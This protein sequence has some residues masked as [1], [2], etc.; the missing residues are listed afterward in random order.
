MVS[1]VA[2]IAL[3]AIVACPI[4]LGY[5]MNLSEITES[6]YTPNDDNLDV[7]NL[8]RDGTDYSYAVANTVDLNS[9]FSEGGIDSY[10]DF[11]VT[12]MRS[13]LPMSKAVYTN[14]VTAAT[15][16]MNDL[17]FHYMVADYVP[18]YSNYLQVAA[19]MNDNSISNIT[20]IHG[21]RFDDTNPGVILVSKF[22]YSNG[23]WIPSPLMSVSNVKALVYTVS[24]GFTGTCETY[25]YNKT[26]PPTT[27]ADL[28]F[29]YYLNKYSK[30][31]SYVDDGTD[32]LIPDYTNNFMFTMD[33][34][35][36]A[37]NK[38]FYLHTGDIYDPYDFKFTKST[39]SG[40]VHWVVSVSYNHGAYEDLTELYYDQSKSSNTYQITVSMSGIKFDY[41]GS[42]PTLFGKA[43][44]Y[45]D[46][47]YDFPNEIGTYL[48]FNFSGSDTPRMR[49]DSAT[50]RAF[51][52]QIIEDET[53]TPSQFRTN[54]ATTISNT[55]IYGTSLTFGGNTYPVSKGNITLGSHQIPVNGLVLSSVL[56]D[57]Q[58]ENRIGN[59]I[60][61]TTA[62]PSTIVFNGKWSTNVSTTSMSETTYTK[63]EWTPGEFGWDG[64]DQNF[65]MVG[66]LTSIGVFIALGIYIRRTK[67]NLW[68]L[69][70]VCGGAAM[71]FFCM[72]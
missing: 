63:T 36:S 13:A 49:L 44:S 20:M 27:Y 71:L 30:S 56:V 64:L 12:T 40:T 65:L 14:S 6:V 21:L 52:Y 37:S 2:V 29:G 45:W 4:L 38:T 62:S 55:Q 16:F 53:Y 66:L 8:L 59:T 11:T 26:N 19:I 1:K 43:N 25:N 69:L 60:V 48:G 41:V 33:F 34:N 61:S 15:F 58:Y 39:V 24:S 67:A 70:V 35:N 31:S 9:R 10:P 46:Y 17:K 28:A 32:I 3:V 23:S 5:A 51:T 42:W 47:S 72:L 22:M 7:T 18:S 50:Y 54:P 68:P 57:G